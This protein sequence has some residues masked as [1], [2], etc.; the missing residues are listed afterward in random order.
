MMKRL[1]GIYVLSLFSS[2][3][4]AQSYTLMTTETS[5]IAKGETST[6]SF[7]IEVVQEIFKR[8]NLGLR[9]KIEPWIRSQK[10]VASADP[11]EG[12]VISPLTRTD[13]RENTYD[14][15][16][17]ITTYKLQF[18][19]NDRTVDISNL[20]GLKKEP[21]CAFRES[22]AEFKLKALGFTKIRTKVQ[23]QKCF[24]GLKKHAE[25]VML[26]H[27]KVS[28]SKGFK[29]A[30]GNPKKLIYGR[31]F[32]E[33]SLYLAST[34]GAVSKRDIEKLRTALDNIKKDGTYA[35]IRD[36]Y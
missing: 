8:S 2:F 36:K 3:A 17:P 4:F 27:G 31:S 34:K 22:P 26:A 14:W 21:I 23:E 20:E 10:K 29:L 7:F 12:L 25:K 1:L 32:A 5:R 9:V 13:E 30:G 15:I 6:E 16:V 28:A 35:M 24:L 18:V 33:E 19:T 11:K